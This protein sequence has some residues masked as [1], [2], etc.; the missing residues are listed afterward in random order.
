MYNNFNFTK[1]KTIKLKNS[2]KHSLGSAAG[3]VADIDTIIIVLEYF[4]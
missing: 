4:T 3:L 2:C 1:Q